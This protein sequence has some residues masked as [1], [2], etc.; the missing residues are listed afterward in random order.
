MQP[1]VLF[2]IQFT[3]SLVAYA[4]IVFWYV[5]PRLSVL[6]REAAIMPLLWIHV[7][8]ITGGD[9]PCS[10]ICRCQSANGVP[11]DDRVW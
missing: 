2:G 5:V 11:S 8:R 3:L 7:F 4:L 9:N 10:R 6:S 1:I